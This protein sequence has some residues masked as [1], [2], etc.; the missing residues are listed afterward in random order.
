MPFKIPG[1]GG[2]DWEQGNFIRRC[3]GISRPK[4]CIKII[5]DK[6]RIQ[7]TV[8]IIDGK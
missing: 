6:S 3:F 4:I 2:Y 7:T 1:D 5:I 8:T